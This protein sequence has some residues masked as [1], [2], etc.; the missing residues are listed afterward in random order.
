M[1]LINRKSFSQPL[2]LYLPFLSQFSTMANSYQKKRK[3]KK[4]AIFPGDDLHSQNVRKASVMQSMYM[5]LNLTTHREFRPY[6]Y[7]WH[8][9]RAIFHHRFIFHA[10]KKKQRQSEKK[11]HSATT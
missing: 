3:R 4:A 5:C 10:K 7:D 9:T 6:D 11:K 2:S 8:S 1:S